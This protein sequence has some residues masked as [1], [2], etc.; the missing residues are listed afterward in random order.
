M[1]FTLA[2]GPK[3]E[4]SF[5]FKFILCYEQI[6]PWISYSVN[7]RSFFNKKIARLTHHWSNENATRGHS[8]RSKNVKLTSP[9]I[10][11]PSLIF[12]TVIYY[13]QYIFIYGICQLYN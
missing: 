5:S 7:I 4:F 9:C 3:P 1:E 6:V 12:A 13:N 11:Y 8:I 10:I 2:F